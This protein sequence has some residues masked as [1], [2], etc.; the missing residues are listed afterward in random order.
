M[1]CFWKGRVCQNKTI[2]LIPHSFPLP[3]FLLENMRVASLLCILKERG[4]WS[5]HIAALPSSVSALRHVM[6]SLT[7]L[8]RALSPSCRSPI[9][10]VKKKGLGTGSCSTLLA[11]S[12]Y[13]LTPT[14]WS[15]TTQPGFCLSGSRLIHPR[16]HERLCGGWKSCNSYGKWHP[17]C[18]PHPQLRLFSHSGQFGWSGVICFC[19][20]HADWSRLLPSQQS[21]RTSWLS[22]PSRQSWQL[23]RLSSWR[24]M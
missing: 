15:P 10:L 3:N 9:K 11:A 20:I 19:S 5:L 7:N 2:H 17:R 6:V 18:S 23:P 14:L 13:W 12:R 4:C 1:T 21:K 24:W 8:A 16:L 22:H